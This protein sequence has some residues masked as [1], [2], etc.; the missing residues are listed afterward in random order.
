MNENAKGKNA[1]DYEIDL[2]AL[3][4][5]KKT[6]H[7]FGTFYILN[8]DPKVPKLEKPLKL[9]SRMTKDKIRE[10]YVSK[11]SIEIYFLS[12]APECYFQNK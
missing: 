6:H 7:S 5:Q 9:H 2:S 12:L 1:N 4:K 10:A 11:H 3:P 8:C